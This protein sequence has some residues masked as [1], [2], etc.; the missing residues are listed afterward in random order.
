MPDG[1]SVAMKVTKLGVGM[2]MVTML[3]TSNVWTERIC[4][5]FRIRHIVSKVKKKNLRTAAISTYLDYSDRASTALTFSS[6]T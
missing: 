6:I 4:N 3:G 2:Y 1:V 5:P